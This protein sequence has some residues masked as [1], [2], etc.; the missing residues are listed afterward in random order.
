MTS[1]PIPTVL[2]CVRVQ[3]MP[4][5]TVASDRLICSRCLAEVWRSKS[6]AWWM[7]TVY[8]VRCALEVGDADDEL[9][10]APWV[11]D[12]LVTAHVIA[13]EGQRIV[14]RSRLD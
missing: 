7:G 14:R 13:R 10:P 3:D 11:R 5:P 12:D 1:R 6:G 8:C 9:V 2:V 4:A